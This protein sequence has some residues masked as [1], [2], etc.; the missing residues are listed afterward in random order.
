MNS[1]TAALAITLSLA[2]VLGACDS[3]ISLFAPADDVNIAT[4]A[5]ADV[6]I[7]LAALDG[8]S[9]G[10]LFNQ[11]SETI[12]GFAGFWLD[13]G[14]NLNVVL[15]AAGKPEIAKEVLTPYLRRYVETH[16]CPDSASIVVHRGEFTWRE[17]SGW[18]RAMAP[19]IEIRGVSRMGISIRLNRLVFAVDGRPTAYDVLRIAE[20]QG[21]PADAIRFVLAASD[22]TTDR[23]RG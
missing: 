17:L 23:T 19:A 18:L 10:S 16:R 8:S 22:A 2:T 12:P 9:D 13:R 6:T 1:P 21:V 20:K 5:T 11:L 3:G 14:C 15:T 7:D 4:D